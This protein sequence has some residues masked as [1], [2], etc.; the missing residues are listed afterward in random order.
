MEASA[1]QARTGEALGGFAQ[2]TAFRRAGRGVSGDGAGADRPRRSY[3]LDLVSYWVALASLGPFGRRYHLDLVAIR[4][5][6]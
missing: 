5:V 1:R 4:V 6:G 3:Q 2:Q